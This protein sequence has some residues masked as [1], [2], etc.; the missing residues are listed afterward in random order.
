MPSDRN[1]HGGMR[2]PRRVVAR[3]FDLFGR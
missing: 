1:Q 2:L 3:R